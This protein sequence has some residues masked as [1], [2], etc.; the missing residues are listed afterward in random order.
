MTGEGE[1]IRRHRLVVITGPSGIGKTPLASALRRRPGFADGFRPVVLEN[2]RAPRPGEADGVDYR[3]RAREE[4]EARRNDDRFVVEDV[5]GDLLALDVEALRETLSAGDA[6]YEG[7]PPFARVLVTDPRL[8]DFD[9]LGVFVSPLSR[10]EVIA[11]RDRPGVD[12]PE[13]VTGYMRRKLL[14]RARRQKGELGTA[15]RE[16]ADRRAGRAYAE[17]LDAPL[18]RHVVPNHD[19]ED[20]EHWHDFPVLLGD[21]RRA[22]ETV[23]AILRGEPAPCAETWEAGLLTEA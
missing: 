11:L 2:S 3:F 7:N 4:I 1:A 15:D 12:L 22:V 16:E 20:S 13:V 5:R 8:D 14:R 19:G 21:A 6:L 17:M 9:R 23:A 10:D 18:Y